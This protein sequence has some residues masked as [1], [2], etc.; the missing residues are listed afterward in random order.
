MITLNKF[1]I[2]LQFHPLLPATITLML[3]IWL[4]SFGYSFY[5]IFILSLL[6]ILSSLFL[7]IWAPL[8]LGASVLIGASF[9]QRTINR[10][11]LLQNTIHNECLDL[12]VT[13]TDITTTDHKFL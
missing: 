10:N 7:D 5:F 3:G 12:T 6:L 4:Q 8:F 2:P 13:I 11:V 9:Y 1:F